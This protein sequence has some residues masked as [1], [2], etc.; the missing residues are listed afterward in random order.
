MITVYLYHCGLQLKQSVLDLMGSAV[1]TD[2]EETF[3]NIS[4][5]YDA[6]YQFVTELDKTVSDWSTETSV[7]THLRTLVSV[8]FNHLCYKLYCY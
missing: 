2:V 6:H 7:G 4:K 5:L 1:D 8:F 3:D